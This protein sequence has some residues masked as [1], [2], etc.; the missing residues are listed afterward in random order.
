MEVEEDSSK[1]EIVS[2]GYGMQG[3]EQTY[4]NHSVNSFMK[5]Y[6]QL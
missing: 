1:L 5:F 4:S 3:R 6:L 2:Y